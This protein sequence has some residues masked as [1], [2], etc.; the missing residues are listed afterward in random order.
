MVQP[1]RKKETIEIILARAKEGF[2]FIS[3]NSLQGNVHRTSC[4]YD[5]EKLQRVGDYYLFDPREKIVRLEFKCP[6]CSLVYLNPISSDE[7]AKFNRLLLI[8]Q[9]NHDLCKERF[10]RGEYGC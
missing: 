1:K 7:Q 3:E 10:L 5:G 4:F 8:N 9:K 6:E 2:D